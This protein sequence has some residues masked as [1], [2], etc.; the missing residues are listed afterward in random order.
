MQIRTSDDG[1]QAGRP[2]RLPPKTPSEVMNC[3]PPFTVV[4]GKVWPLLEVRPATYRFR[5][6]NGSNARTYRLA[7]LRRGAPAPRRVRQVRGHPRLPPTPPPPPPGG[8]A[9]PPPPRAA[10]PSPP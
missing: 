9:C 7:P 8:R 1:E 3:H 6:L 5:V 2:G 4:N 10:P